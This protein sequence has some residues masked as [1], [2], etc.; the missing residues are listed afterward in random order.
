MNSNLKTMKNKLLRY[1]NKLMK[2]KKKKKK[3]KINKKKFI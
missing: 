2:K 1:C 3:I